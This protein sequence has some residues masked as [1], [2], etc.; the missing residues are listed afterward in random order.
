MWTSA[1]RQDAASTMQA[2]GESTILHVTRPAEHPWLPIPID[3]FS[4]GADASQ[5]GIIFLY[6]AN[7]L[8]PRYYPLIRHLAEAGYVT[9]VPRFLAQPGRGAALG[10]AAR[11]NF[12][13]WIGTLVNALMHIVSRPGVDP[14]RMGLVGISL[15]ASL[16]L[17]LAAHCY[18]LKAVVDWYGDVPEFVIERAFR[19]P[20]TLILHGGLDRQV[21][22]QKVRRLAL[23]LR[24]ESVPCELQI[25]PGERHVFQPSLHLDAAIRTVKFFEKHI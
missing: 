25:Y 10:P 24:Q 5:P 1:L 4:L 18:A 14:T 15:G 11:S 19:M 12:P 13:Y 21:P 23:A 3:V 9:F 7:G 20:P 8:S 17:A 22:A 16:G 2:F 6:G